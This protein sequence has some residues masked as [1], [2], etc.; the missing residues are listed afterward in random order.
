MISNRNRTSRADVGPASGEVFRL[1]TNASEDTTSAL[2]NQVTLVI[3][4][5]GPSPARARIAGIVFVST[6]GVTR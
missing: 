1:P 2:L 4:L 3:H 6:A 5:V